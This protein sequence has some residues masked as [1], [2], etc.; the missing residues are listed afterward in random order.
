MTLHGFGEVTTQ[1][2]GQALSQA[3][4]ILNPGTYTTTWNGGVLYTPAAPAA[5]IGASAPGNVSNMLGGASASIS[6]T[7]LLVIAA[8]AFFMFK[9]GK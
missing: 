2:I 5:S 6:P 8:V 7:T 9:G 4:T 3:G 1:D